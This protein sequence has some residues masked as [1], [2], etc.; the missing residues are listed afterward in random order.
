MRSSMKTWYQ[1]INF[2]ADM[3]K[4]RN[5]SGM[6]AEAVSSLALL[7]PLIVV[8]VF[9]AIQGSNAYVI[10]RHMNQGAQIA[11]RSLAEEY[12]TNKDLDTDTNAQNAIFSQIRLKDMIASNTQFTIPSGGWQTNTDPKT[13]TVICTYIPGAGNPALPPFPNPNILG[14]GAS[15][16]ISMSATYRLVE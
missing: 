14:L 2:K 3:R 10:A 8:I 11:A 6:L 9:V 16:K 7:L 15:F 13:V 1:R 4:S 12:R 5:A